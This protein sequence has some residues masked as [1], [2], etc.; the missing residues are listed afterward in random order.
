MSLSWIPR[1]H[2]RRRSEIV[3][4]TQDNELRRSHVSKRTDVPW[5]RSKRAEIIVWQ[6]NRTSR[7]FI[8]PKGETGRRNF[9]KQRKIGTD[10]VCCVA[11]N[12][13]RK[14]L[15]LKS[16]IHPFDGAKQ[17]KSQASRI[18]PSNRVKQKKEK[19][20]TRQEYISLAKFSIG[21]RLTRSSRHKSIV[22]YSD[23]DDR[24]LRLKR[25]Y[26]EGDR[27]KEVTMSFFPWKNKKNKNK[28][29][30]DDGGAVGKTIF[31]FKSIFGIY[32]L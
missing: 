19:S 31:Y 32:V 2:A 13:R 17:E 27:E 8:L 24:R 18:H 23:R 30:K 10:R 29:D 14:R 22:A 12:K 25:N 5:I 9:A 15:W 26:S 1:P 28:A 3:A 6:G 7:H 4:Q 11:W 21:K 20:L 16:K